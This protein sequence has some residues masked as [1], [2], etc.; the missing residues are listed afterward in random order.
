V[1]GLLAALAQGEQGEHGELPS[2]SGLVS[3]LVLVTLYAK[4]EVVP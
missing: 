3:S 1:L 4:S 2:P